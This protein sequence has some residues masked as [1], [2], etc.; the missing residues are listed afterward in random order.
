MEIIFIRVCT[1]PDIKGLTL[2]AYEF[3]LISFADDVSYFL[4]NLKSIKGLLWLLKY[5]EQFTSLKVNYEKSEICSI[6]SKKG[7]VGA[8]SNITS[9]DIVNDNV[10]ILGCHHSYNKQLA[11]DRNFLDTVVNI[12]SVLNLRSWRGPSLLH[13]G[14]IQIFKTLQISK[15]HYLASICLMYLIE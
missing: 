12:Q 4:Q 1:N 14:K 6:G 13:E 9:V 3:K 15:I 2:F 8:F 11:D 5:S 10:K 7:V